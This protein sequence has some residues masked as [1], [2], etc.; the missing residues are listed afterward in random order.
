[1][2][3]IISDRVLN[4]TALL[5]DLA[6]MVCDKAVCIDLDTQDVYSVAYENGEFIEHVTNMKWAELRERMIE[7]TI[8]DQRNQ[9][10]PFF[11]E[12]ILDKLK[13]KRIIR[14]SLR[15]NYQVD[16]SEYIWRDVAVR[17]L[18]HNGS[19][20]LLYYTVNIAGASLEYNEYDN[21]VYDTETSLYSRKYLAKMI[22]TEY[23]KLDS[24]QVLLL[25]LE[26]LNIMGQSRTGK[27]VKRAAEAALSLRKNNCHLYRYS[28]DE[29]LVVLLNGTGEDVDE[30]R[31]EWQERM[32]YLSANDAVKYMLLTASASATIPFSVYDLI[33]K[34]ERIAFTKKKQYEK[35]A[36]QEAEER[37]NKQ[38]INRI[39][40]YLCEDYLSLYEIDLENDTYETVIENTDPKCRVVPMSGC[41]S[42][43]FEKECRLYVSGRSLEER[44][45]V[46]SIANLRKALITEKRVECEFETADNSCMWRRAIF[47][48]TKAQEG[49]PK[50]VVMAHVAIDTS[51]VER[52]RKQKTLVDAFQEQEETSNV[53]KD[54]ISKMSHDIRTPLNAIIGM[55]ML[56]QNA[57]S[58]RRKVDECLSKIEAASNQMLE[59][60]NELLDIRKIETGAMELAH[61]IFSVAELE[62]QVH[63]LLLPTAEEHKHKFVISMHDIS[64]E[65]L[66]G[67]INRIQ[68]IVNNIVSNSIKYTP[69]GGE[70]SM[71]I[72]EEPGAD[73]EHIVLH[74]VF[75]DN[76]VGMSDEFLRKIYDPF[77]RAYDPRVQG[78]TGTGLGMAITK[79]LV[80]LMGGTI[81]IDSKL[82]YG[83]TTMVDIPIEVRKFNNKE[84]I[85]KMDDF[86]LFVFCES[87]CKH[88]ECMMGS[89]C[90]CD[91][92]NGVGL[93]LY[94][95]SLNDDVKLIDFVKQNSAVSRFAAIII[96][97]KYTEENGDKIKEIRK[98]LG[99]GVPIILSIQGDWLD[100]ELEARSKGVN[101]FI[102]RPILLKELNEMIQDVYDQSMKEDETDE[103]GG[104]PDCTGKRILV[105]EDN[106]IN[107]EIIIEIL[108]M[109]GATIDRAANGMIAFEM[110]RDVPEGW[111]NLILMDIEMPLMNG[112]EATKNIRALDRADVKVLP[113]VAMTANAFS[114]DAQMAIEAGMN[115]HLTKPIEIDRLEKMLRDYM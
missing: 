39:R 65:M 105:A 86:G 38:R 19:R 112:Y 81:I 55:T 109:S 10:Q 52:M 60:V 43:V 98:K 12:R 96:C 110:M 67:D 21:T 24:C 47:Q 93:S 42:Q 83:T 7:A 25:Y 3:K 14:F 95:Y 59:L 75:S 63:N 114:S 58:D 37:L 53:R 33:D 99:A 69:D 79:N 92:L 16:G 68:R 26:E 103:Q 64:E 4:N 48:V 104:F 108:S 85:K 34:C 62:M 78:R 61:D 97:R 73:S 8:F 15:N 107:A 72:S 115:E 45:R 44:L 82:N 102:R 74:L 57:G 49:I 20:L 46:G 5:K 84:L 36:I 23:L 106:D 29:I 32:E 71:D 88:D 113:I 91:V 54:F 100:I 35:E 76:G 41:Y 11:D 6:E 1:M 101:Y 27:A 31:M 87:G 66:L 94:E 56:A 17:T 2:G 13:E 89:K 90:L 77:S 28:S 50:K 111:Y 9:V 70:I 22:K 40:E 30:Y 51:E 80:N 18:E